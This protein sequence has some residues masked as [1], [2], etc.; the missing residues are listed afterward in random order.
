MAFVPA[1]WKSL[2]KSSKDLFDK[3]KKYEFGRALEVNAAAGNTNWK[4]EGNLENS[5][6]PKS[7]AKLTGT[8]NHPVVG[9]VELTVATQEDKTKVKV[10]NKKLVDGAKLELTLEQG[11]KYTGGVTYQRDSFSA[12]AEAS[13]TSSG[14]AL[15]GSAVLGYGSLSVGAQGVFE[16]SDQSSDVS[17]FNVALS[18][19][20][21]GLTATLKTEDK[22]DMVNAYVQTPYGSDV[23][24][25]LGF[26]WSMSRAEQRF[27]RVGGFKSLDK[28]SQV[29][30]FVQV[31]QTGHSE[32]VSQFQHD[33]SSSARIQ[34]N[35]CVDAASLIK[36]A[37][38]NPQVG[39]KLALG[40]L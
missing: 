19:T 29:K 4:F 34:L 17:D 16:S 20:D 25:H 1:L 22:A 27:A 7:D 18:Y 2:G 31:D 5:T 32:I 26:T 10:T 33:L 30:G 21:G 24:V 11:G 39:W 3:K 28:S 9:Q 14:I 12:N 13:Y 38:F 6:S 35:A 15:E 37:Q 40:D 36:T 8:V 23:D